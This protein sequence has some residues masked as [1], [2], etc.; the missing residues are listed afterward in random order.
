[1][2]LGAYT[3]KDPTFGY[4]TYEEL[5]KLRKVDNEN[6]HQEGIFNA[7]AGGGN[8]LSLSALGG[9]QT[10]SVLNNVVIHATAGHQLVQLQTINSH[11]FERLRSFY[12]GIQ[13]GT[14]KPSLTITLGR[15][16]TD[17]E[18]IF[19]MADI[20]Q[21]PELATQTPHYKGHKWLDWTFEQL[22]PI[23][24]KCLNLMTTAT[25]VNSIK[26]ALDKKVLK[27][28]AENWSQPMTFVHYI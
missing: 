16:R 10:S 22:Y 7:S 14:T 8:S 4:V 11:E 19:Q 15:V 17:I 27:S 26:T 21:V 6:R 24:K 20:T 3:I 2:P 25:D 5:Q 9:S 18:T 28:T 23:L 13:P 1:M 12:D